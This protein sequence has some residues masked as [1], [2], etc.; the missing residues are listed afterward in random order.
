MNNFKSNTLDYS[1]TPYNATALINPLSRSNV[2]S[3]IQDAEVLISPLS[4]HSKY[5]FEL[6]LYRA[7]KV[8]PELNTISLATLNPM[9]HLFPR[10]LDFTSSN[11]SSNKA[12]NYCLGS[13]KIFKKY[14]LPVRTAPFYVQQ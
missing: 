14:P 8:L 9:I 6:A 3:P 12:L 10:Y 11:S 1:T 2:S 13:H 4:I 7:I 5:H